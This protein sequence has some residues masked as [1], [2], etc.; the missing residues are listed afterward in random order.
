LRGVIEVPDI[1]AFNKQWRS[2]PFEELVEIFCDD[3]SIRNIFRFDRREDLS[4]G[5]IS[6]LVQVSKVF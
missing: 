6:D 3:L 4:R 5:E 2:M 1:I